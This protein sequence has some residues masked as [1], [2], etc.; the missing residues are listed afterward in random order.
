MKEHSKGLEAGTKSRYPLSGRL[1]RRKDL[2][3]LPQVVQCEERLSRLETSH[4]GYCMRYPSVLDLEKIIQDIDR[5]LVVRRHWPWYAVAFNP[6][7][8]GH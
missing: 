4:R 5:V 6:S 1:R 2:A 8:S 3:C 7:A